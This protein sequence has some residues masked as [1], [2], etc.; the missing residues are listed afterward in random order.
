MI[1]LET[2]LLRTDK[3]HADL[4]AGLEPHYVEALAFKRLLERKVLT[5]LY[6]QEARLNRRADKILNQ[7][8]GE[9]VAVPP[10]VPVPARATTASPRPAPT[11]ILKNE[12][13]APAV[14]AKVGRNEPCPCG[15]TLKFK[16]CCG[17]PLN[18]GPVATL[19]M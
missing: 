16:L 18:P 11:P 2:H 9:A 5:H 7:L 12:P 14:S 6:N 15:S 17:N 13:T 1:A 3:D 19:S 8:I 4:I 10:A